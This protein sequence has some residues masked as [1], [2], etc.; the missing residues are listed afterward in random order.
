MSAKAQVIDYLLTR[1]SV[2]QAFLGEP[3]PD[4]EQLR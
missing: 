1:R 4:P 3:G 2:G